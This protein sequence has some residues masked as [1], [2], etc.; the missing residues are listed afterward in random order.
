MTKA[1]TDYK[2]EFF[3]KYKE[4]RSV[5]TMIVQRRCLGVGSFG[6][7]TYEYRQHQAGGSINTVLSYSDV[8]EKEKRKL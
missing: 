3:F 1:G 4:E 7:P 8:C 6:S 5:I 2:W